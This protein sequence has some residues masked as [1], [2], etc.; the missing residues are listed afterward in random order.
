M[1]RRASAVRSA[2]AAGVRA[3]RAAPVDIL[4]QPADGHAHVPQH[5]AGGALRTQ[6]HSTDGESSPPPPPPRVC[7]SIHPEGKPCGQ[8]P[9]SVRVLVLKDP[10]A[11][12]ASF[13]FNG[14][15]VAADDVVWPFRWGRPHS[16]R[17]VTQRILNP[18]SSS[19][20][21]SYDVASNIWQA[22]SIGPCTTCCRCSGPC[23]PSCTSSSSTPPSRHGGACLN[24][25][26]AVL[27]APGFSA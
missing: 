3:H 14:I 16:A 6:Q 2:L 11:W 18:R 17:H 23:A 20:T 26:N 1:T 10:A 5:L 13:L 27:K 22:L 19:Q 9:I 15:L 24:V 21:A 25:L 8:R 7:M 4:R 12:F